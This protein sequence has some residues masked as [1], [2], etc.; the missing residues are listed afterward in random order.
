MKTKHPPRTLDHFFADLADKDM[1]ITDWARQQGFSLSSVYQVTRGR[2]VG[3]RGE[4]RK[5]ARAMGLGLPTK[6]ASKQ[7]A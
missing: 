5:I 4:A 2:T 3:H 1:S 7:A 6:Q